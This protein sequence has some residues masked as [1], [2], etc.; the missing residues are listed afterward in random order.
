MS[1]MWWNNNDK[2]RAWAMM[3]WEK[4]AIPREW[5]EWALGTY[6]CS[7]WLCWADRSGGL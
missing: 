7:T 4:C 2:A 3:A 5:E 1:R 6:S